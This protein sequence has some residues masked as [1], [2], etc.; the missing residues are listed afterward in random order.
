MLR[1]STQ[2]HSY[3]LP[4]FAL[5]FFVLV[6]GLRLYFFAFGT[7]VRYKWQWQWWWWWW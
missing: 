5:C 6:F 2:K 3:R 7:S 1:K 4:A